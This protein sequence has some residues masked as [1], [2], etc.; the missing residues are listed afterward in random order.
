MSPAP[1]PTPVVGVGAVCVR[2]GRLLVV[3][4]GRAPAAGAW[5]LP[6]GRQEP[7]ETLQ[8]AVA[9][10]L[11]EETGL[12]GVVGPLCGIAERMG[13]GYHYV[14]LDFWVDVTGDAVAADDAEET[15]WASRADL[16]RLA[17]VA[18]LNE[19]LAQHGVL[20]QLA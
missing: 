6:G 14:I 16:K 2:G 15:A 7:G 10:E 5:A 8:E 9:R 13:A 1:V 19:W 18:S 3:R 11:A 17:L 20:D 12:T 4:R